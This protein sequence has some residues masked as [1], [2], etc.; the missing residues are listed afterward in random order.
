MEIGRSENMRNNLTALVD[1]M[2][3]TFVD[4]TDPVKVLSLF[5]FDKSEFVSMDKGRFGYQKGLRAG[6]CNMS[7]LYAGMPGMGVHVD[8]SGS[9]VLPVLQK[10]YESSLVEVPFGGDA[11]PVDSMSDTVLVDFLKVILI[12]G[13]K[14]SRLDIAVDD[15]GCSFFTAKDIC[16]LV[17]RDEYSSRFRCGR[18]EEGF[19]DEQGMT[20]YF[21]SRKS[22]LM[23]RVYDKAAELEDKKKVSDVQ[24]CTRWELEL[25]NEYAHKVAGMLSCGDLIGKVCTGILANYIRFINPDNVRK[26][27]CTTLDSW[28]DFIGSASKLLLYQKRAPSTVQS[29]YDWIKHQCAPTF[30]M[31]CLAFDGDIDFLT[32]LLNNGRLRLSNR[33]QEML[34][35]FRTSY[36]ELRDPVFRKAM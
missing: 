15:I 10:F 13:G 22:D 26:S 3:F 4:I 28:L 20:V 34:D 5:H 35:A 11:F 17:R 33:H 7:L 2:S 14:F 6:F 1:W 25:K 30:A 31:L 23:L 32:D 29:C 9:A 27:R 24:S 12:N 21:G 8:I 16:E 19:G 36:S 18:I